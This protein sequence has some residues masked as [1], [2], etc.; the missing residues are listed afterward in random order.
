MRRH[1]K[2]MA[3]SDHKLVGLK[4]YRNLLQKHETESCRQ[5]TGEDE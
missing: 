4:N 5:K 2:L 1:G 3:F